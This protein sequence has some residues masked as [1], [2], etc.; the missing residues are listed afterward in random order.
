M[1]GNTL[2]CGDLQRSCWALPVDLRNGTLHF[3]VLLEVLHS[4]HFGCQVCPWKP[5]VWPGKIWLTIETRL[6][7][8]DKSRIRDIVKPAALRLVVSDGII[9]VKAGDGK[10][11]EAML[12][13]AIWSHIDHKDSR[14]TKKVSKISLEM[15]MSQKPNNWSVSI[16]LFQLAN[17]S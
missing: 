9:R 2:P 4:S 15:S 11:R 3:A 8:S 14:S 17:L 1:E 5:C 16:A 6:F 13:Y 7:I 10:V 12:E